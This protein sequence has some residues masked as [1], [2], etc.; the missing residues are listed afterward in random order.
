MGMGEDRPLARLRE[1][2]DDLERA[3]ALH[4]ERDRILRRCSRRHSL[5]TLA[6]HSGLSVSRLHE[7]VSGDRTGRS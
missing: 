3:S 6:R 4:V 2:R 1:I 7:I 5:R